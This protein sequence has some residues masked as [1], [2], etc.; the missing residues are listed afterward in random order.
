MPKP[1]SAE[2]VVAITAPLVSVMLSAIETSMGAPARSP[3]VS[4]LM[5]DA[6]TN[7]WPPRM[8]IDPPP[9]L[10]SK[11]SLASMNAKPEI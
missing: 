1:K 6:S 10:P 8:M 2:A 11:A 3:Y 9:V 7:N 4:A 5:L